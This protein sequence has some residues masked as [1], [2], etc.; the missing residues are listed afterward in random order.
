M[1]E[2]RNV[3]FEIRLYA[4]FSI[5]SD[6]DK[7]AVDTAMSLLYSDSFRED[8]LIPELDDPLQWGDALADCRVYLD[9][10]QESHETCL[11]REYIE[12]LTRE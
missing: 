4:N 5:E 11:T 3:T 8:E 1:A 7:D 12:H 10:D 6:N 9:S 2:T